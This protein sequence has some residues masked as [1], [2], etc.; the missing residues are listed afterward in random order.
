MTVGNNNTNIWTNVMLVGVAIALLWVPLNATL[1]IKRAVGAQVEVEKVFDFR[2]DNPL[3]KFV[4][5]LSK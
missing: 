3:S 1:T 4:R 5:W 2:L